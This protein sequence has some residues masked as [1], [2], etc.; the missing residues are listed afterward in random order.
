MKTSARILA[1]L[2]FSGSSLIAAVP[3]TINYQGVVADSQGDL[4]APST[5]LN[6]KVIFRIFD[7]ST[8]GTRLWTEEQTVTIYKGEFSVLLGAGTTATGTAS[9]ETRP[10]FDTVF[11]AATTSRFIEIMVDN[12][13]GVIN[14]SD[15]PISPRQS[16]TSAAFAFRSQVAESILSGSDLTITPTSGTAS[17]YGLGWY[18]S[19]RQWNG[20]SVDGPVLYGNSGGVLGSN[21]SGNRNTALLWDASGRVGIGAI[22][23]FRDTNKLVLQGNDASTPA[24]QM[25]IRGNSD[26]SKRLLIGFDTT[27][28]RA[29][30][31]SYTAT[32]TTG[33]LLLNPVSGLVGIGTSAPSARLTVEG[34]IS[35]T[36]ASG[37][38]FGTGGDVD[39][40]LFSPSDGVVTLKT[41][42][43]E[44]LRADSDGRVSVISKLGIG[45]TTPTARL[46]ISDDS[47]VETGTFGSV[48]INRAATGH[49]GAHLSFCR[50]GSS[51]FG[52]GYGQSSST[53]GF[54]PGA[55][56]AFTPSWLGFDPS[57]NVGIG[58]APASPYKLDVA[59]R[60]R[61]S[62]QA[63]FDNIVLMGHDDAIF[64]KTN[65]GVDEGAFWARGA[66]NGTYLNFGTGGL[67]LR[68]NTNASKMQITND[69]IVQIGT[70]GT[71]ARLCIGKKT[72]PSINTIGYLDTHGGQSGDSTQ[73]RDLSITA[74]GMILGEIVAVFSDVRIK[75][76]LHVSDTAK[77]LETLKGIEITDYHY[78]DKLAS[79]NGPQKKVIAQ[80]VETVYPQAVVQTTGVVPDLFKKAAV[81]N[82]WVEL[83]SDLK[84]GDRVKL[85]GK[86]AEAIHEVLEIRDGA[87]RPDGQVDDEQVFVYG[88]EVKDFR[89]VDYDAIS[90]LNVSATQELARKLE[91]VQAE[92]AAL[93]RELAEQAK[94]AAAQ[95][96]ADTAQNARLI[97]LEKLLTEKAGDLQTVTLKAGK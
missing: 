39:G 21:A 8:G 85:I 63:D 17:N 51:D 94:H 24:Q 38:I 80:Q 69:G 86:K 25:M 27:N 76:D 23:D 54:G 50:V 29:T 34:S 55:T 20:I 37:Y 72:T 4:L 75:T 52:L 31:Q 68:D 33:P 70:G 43:S 89:T 79:G 6:R 66:N 93:R 65:G 92:N 30:L 81:T 57:G 9:S 14:S 49:V 84:K 58:K 13:D 2:L 28:N 19:G 61:I 53:A 44:R 45:T 32:S 12:G 62:E 64:G 40:G 22:G 77:D 78:K 48:Q 1:F 56:G 73:S 35:A 5:P 67:F 42:G 82:G 97:A 95:A 16:I 10:A 41:N 60:V 18:G 36:G 7:A 83:A 47:V 59:G 88:R 11:T 74:E 3:A 46:T 71:S 26:A 87:F 96:D 15:S 90:M 91:T